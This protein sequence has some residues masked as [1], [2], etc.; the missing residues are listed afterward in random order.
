MKQNVHM[1]N[2]DRGRT[3]VHVLIVPTV[4]RRGG[5]VRSNTP[6]YRWGNG[7]TEQ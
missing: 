6:F 3:W 4:P 7:G 1:L 5:T 2:S